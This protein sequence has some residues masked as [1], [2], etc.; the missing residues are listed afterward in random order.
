MEYERR[1]E[2][3]EEDEDDEEYIDKKHTQF[4]ENLN[5]REIEA[6]IDEQA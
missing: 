2:E 6:L 4:L 1:E 3:E 5:P